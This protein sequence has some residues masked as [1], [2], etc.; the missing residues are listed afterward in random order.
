LED[1]AG[2]RFR[3][4]QVPEMSDV[5]LARVAR[6]I[7]EA[8]DS[9]PPRFRPLG[10]RWA[11]LAAMLGSTVTAG[12]AIIGVRAVRTVMAEAKAHRQATPAPTRSAHTPHASPL[13]AEPPLAVT[14]PP[15]PT[16]SVS[17][18]APPPNPE[19]VPLVQVSPV[20]EVVPPNHRPAAQHAAAPT[21]LTGLTGESRMLQAAIEQL[22]VRG[23]ATSALAQLDAYSETFP[24]GVLAREAEVA[25]VDALLRLGR[26]AEALGL[27]DAA[28][29]RN[30]EG[31]PRPAQLRV[32]RGELLA[33][34][35]RCSEAIPIFSGALSD[36]QTGQASE[37]ALYGRANC[38]ATL[39]EGAASRADLET[40]LELYPQGHFAA[41]ARRALSK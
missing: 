24:H 33:T 40:Y 18:S 6:R 17:P 30:F 15:D 32:L 10:L 22:N 36:A 26:D 12:A 23:N 8:I 21:G 16:P 28:S 37:R 4:V 13:P 7:S 20:E 2:E 35:G 25:R 11:V 41:E 9:P 38:R 1:L 29:E 31:Y 3:E 19:H 14:P 5:Q 34:L 39:G 27:L